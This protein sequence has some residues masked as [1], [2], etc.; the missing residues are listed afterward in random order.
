MRNYRMIALLCLGLVL[1]NSCSKPVNYSELVFKNAIAYKGTSEKPFSGKAIK[2][3]KLSETEII[4]DINYIN[5]IIEGKSIGK[6]RDGGIA[7]EL[8]YKSGK[9]HGLCSGYYIGGNKE[10]EFNFENGFPVGKQ[11]CWYKEGTMKA[12]LD[13]NNAHPIVFDYDVTGNGDK[14]KCQYFINNDSLLSTAIKILK[15]I[16]DKQESFVESDLKHF[17]FYKIP[18]QHPL[19]GYLD[20]MGTISYSNNAKSGPYVYTYFRDGEIIPVNKF[21]KWFSDNGFVRMDESNWRNRKIWAKY[22]TV[23]VGN[24]QSVCIT[25]FNASGEKAFLGLAQ[26]LGYDL[27]KIK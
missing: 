25:I 4:S 5:G 11:K 20:E 18:D 13:L 1:F 2:T 21:D 3:E 24:S 6:Y 22:L 16:I 10:F 17:S 7:W 23:A 26:K 9:Y 15:R 8:N 19:G 27:S 12:E 14:I